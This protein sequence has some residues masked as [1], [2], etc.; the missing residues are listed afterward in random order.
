M[1]LGFK[2]R[3]SFVI[4]YDKSVLLATK[5][6]DV[7]SVDVEPE[8]VDMDSSSLVRSHELVAG[9]VLHLEQG[10]D[11]RQLVRHAELL[12]HVDVGGELGVL[13]ELIEQQRLAELSS[14]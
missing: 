10:V 3:K 6:V 9:Y 7:S 8:C 4:D 1:K 5:D 11:H 2:F 14:F 13:I 12:V